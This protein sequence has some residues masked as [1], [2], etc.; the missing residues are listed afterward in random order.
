MKTDVPN[1]G[2]DRFYL[3]FKRV[4][5]FELFD[6]VTGKEFQAIAA[7]CLNERRPCSVL[8]LDTTTFLNDF[9]RL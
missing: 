9:V 2:L 1:A 3:S 5:V 6:S 8:G 7:L 4:R